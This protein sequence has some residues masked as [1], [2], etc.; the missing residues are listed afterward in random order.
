MSQK[1]IL[2]GDR[3]SGKLHLGHYVGSLH[4]RVQLQEKYKQYVMI[5]DMQALTDNF[6][7]PG[8]ILHNTYEVAKDYLAVGIDPEKTIIFIQ[9]QVTALAEITM[10]FM[11][12]VNLGRLE[13][14]PTVKTEL[15]Q[16]GFEKEIPVGQ[17]K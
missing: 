12:L 17:W 8:N 2:T 5:A 10:Y 3:P 16:K 7:T 1:I 4:S 15:Q 13:R 11:N 6:E 9:S 14:N